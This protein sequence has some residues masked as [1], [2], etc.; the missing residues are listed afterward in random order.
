MAVV[1]AVVGTRPNF[2]KMAPVVAELRRRPDRFRTVVVHTGQHYDDA[3]S[4]V[5]LEQLGLGAPDHQ[6]GV[7]SGSHT[8]QTARV[9]ERL[10][11]VLR[12]EQPDV[13]LVPGDVNSTIA[14]ALAASQQDIAVGHVEAGLRSF[15]WTMPE[16]R[17][18]VL[19]DTLSRWLFIH[20]PEARDNLLAEGRPAAHIHA[21]GNTMIDTLVAMRGAI[22]AAAAHNRLGLQRG[23]YVVATL[24]RP[25]LVD[26]PLLAPVVAALRELAHDVPVVLPAHPRTRAAVARAG[27][28]LDPV[29]VL[30]PLGYVEFLSLVSGARAVLTDSGGL[31]EETTWLGVPCFTLR[32]N[33]ERPVTV[34]EGTNTML[35]LDAGR[36][37]AIPQLLSA[38][39]PARARVPAGWDGR[40]AA[41]IVDVLERESH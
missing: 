8:V 15:D 18:R 38:T 21:V 26:G 14:A 34:V 23:E 6:L 31:Q 9:L 41:R 24:H 13:V 33:T 19:T 28:Q 35:G 1:L 25:A 2:M 39:R 40:A 11:P 10:E 12:D 7:G 29:L 27:L 37:R 16:E 5:F 36:I 22:D 17:N 3:M 32:Q 30:E 4:R 20:S